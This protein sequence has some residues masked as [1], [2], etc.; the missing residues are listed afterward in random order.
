MSQEPHAILAFG[1]IVE[2]TTEVERR[3]GELL[4]NELDLPVASYLM[5]DLLERLGKRYGLTCETPYQSIGGPILIGAPGT[6]WR[7]TDWVPGVKSVL[8]DLPS[9]FLQQNMRRLL[10]DLGHA[11]LDLNWL[12]IADFG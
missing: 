5:N 2:F 6:F 3:I 7:V 1:A 9:A 11:D 8:P 4:R 12:L 10:A